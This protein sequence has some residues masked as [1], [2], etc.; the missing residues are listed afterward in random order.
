M[1]DQ[2]LSLKD[3]I[4]EALHR[5][6]QMATTK[7]QQQILVYFQLLKD[8]SGKL[9]LTAI[10]DNE[11][12]AIRHLLDCLTVLPLLD[13]EAEQRSA[14]CLVDVGSGA[15]FPGLLIKIM[16]PDWRC[17]LLDSLAKRIAFLQ[18]VIE[19]LL[20]TEVK[21]EHGRAEDAGRQKR[22]RDQH[23]LAIARAV[24]PLNILAEYCLP[25]VK[26]GGCFIAM[27]GAAGPEWPL[28]RLAVTSLGGQLEQLEEFN[29]PGTDMQR[30]LFLLRKLTATP[31]RFPRRAGRISKNPL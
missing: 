10:T 14:P 19:K 2:E 29:L 18:T 22:L 13:H 15:G 31:E 17:L 25:L 9:N 12:I 6:G 8:Y 5:A 23:D 16:R 11:G 3:W 28:A 26:P 1:P 30:S 7:Q 24:A 21:A 20:L 27:K 4:G